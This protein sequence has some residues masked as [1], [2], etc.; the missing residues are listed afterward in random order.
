MSKKG[1]KLRV[2]LGSHYVHRQLR[3]SRPGFTTSPVNCERLPTLM[4]C[5]GWLVVKAR[6]KR[7]V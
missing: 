5:T 6:G 2:G 7:K 1:A 3:E 4:G